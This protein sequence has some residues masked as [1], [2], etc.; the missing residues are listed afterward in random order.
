MSDNCRKAIYTSEINALHRASVSLHQRGLSI[1]PLHPKSKVPAVDWK[2]YQTKQPLRGDVEWWFGRGAEQNVAIVTGAVSGVVVV[3]VDY[4]DA[5]HCL[6]DLPRTP[7]VKTSRGHHYY[8]AHPGRQV[9][10]F[11]LPCGETR[12]DGG[13]VVAPPSLHESGTRYE[14]IIGLDEP[15]AALP[16]SVLKYEKRL[17]VANDN[18][19]TTNY[20]R[21]WFNDVETL[22]KVAS[23][24]RNILLN[25]VAC[26]AGSLIASGH[27]EEREAR[28]AMGA[29][30]QQNGLTADDGHRSVIATINSGLKKGHQ[31]PRYPLDPLTTEAVHRGGKLVIVRASEIK[32]EKPS[33]LWDGVLAKRSLSILAGDQGLGKS[34]VNV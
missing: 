3:D 7:T 13:Y 8:F 32:E 27:L 24:R 19:Q 18:G 15:L 20:G 16:D 23:G 31:N 4:P 30:C 14:W 21:A 5:V 28:A 33:W 1:I 6:G 25:E 2:A 9:G 34:Q 29:A 26:K 17:S 11:K 22:S 12:G 10:N